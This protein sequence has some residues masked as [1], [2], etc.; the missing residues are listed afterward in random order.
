MVK[1]LLTCLGTVYT[2]VL[3]G[4][5]FHFQRKGVGGGGQ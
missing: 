1:M 4:D 2:A 3:V 5:E